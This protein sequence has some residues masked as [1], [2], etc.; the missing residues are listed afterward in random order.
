MVAA[1]MDSVDIFV[2][3]LRAGDLASVSTGVLSRDV[4]RLY[5][6]WCAQLDMR[7]LN[8]SRFVNALRWRYQVRQSRV[9]YS[10]NGKQ[11]GPHGI[12]HLG[13]VAPLGV[14]LARFRAYVQAYEHGKHA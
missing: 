13:D 12:L 7:P 6:A 3:A 8:M 2:S 11:C 10:L 4:F 14:Q 9:R 5:R 1:G